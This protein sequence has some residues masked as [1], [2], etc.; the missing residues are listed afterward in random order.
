MNWLKDIISGRVRKMSKERMVICKACEHYN[1]GIC[2]DCG[3]VLQAKTRV[4]FMLDDDGI[5]IDGC[6]QRKW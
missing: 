1:N 3:C 2:D 5:S 4:D 6:P